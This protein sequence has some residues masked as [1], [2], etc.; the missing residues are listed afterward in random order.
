M[1]GN[2]IKMYDKQGSVLRVETTINDVDDFKTFRAP[3]N[4]RDV[5]PSRQR[6]RKGVADP[7]LRRGRLCTAAPKSRRLPTTVTFRRLPQ[8]MTPSR[9][10]IW[11][12]DSA[13]RRATRGAGFGHR[14]RMRRATPQMR[15]PWSW[16]IDRV[17]TRR[18][19]R[20]RRVHRDRR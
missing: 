12:P 19:A 4:Q 6:M 10:V 8:R 2:S 7:D 3:E 14:T 11:R 1:G 17:R 15:I 18:A 20:W 16:P 13:G 9:S 5:Q